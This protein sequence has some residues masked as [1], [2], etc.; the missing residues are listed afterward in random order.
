[1]TALLPAAALAQLIDQTRAP[2]AAGDGIS[3]SYAQQV[4][5][6][7]G[8]WSTPDSSSFI[9]ARDPFRAIRRGRQL[10]NR[11]F[12]REQGVGPI[13]GDGVGDINTTLAIGA[14]LSDSCAGCHGMPRGSAGFGGGVVT[15]PDGRN[16]PHLFGLGLREMLA[17][18][19]TA[20]L[21]ARR[22]EA[23]AAARR[24]QSRIT[25]P[26]TAK[27]IDYG[28]ITAGPDDAVDLSKLKGVDHDL[29]V[30][31]FFAHGGAYS[32][33]EFVVGALQNEMGMQAVDPDLAQAAAG[34]R[35]V[36]VA[37]MTLDGAL[38]KLD[39]P[40]AANA[41]ADP[42]GDGVANEA[43]QAAVDYLEFYLLNYFKPGH[44]EQNEG[45]AHGREVFTRIGCPACHIPDLQID[46]DR[47]VADVETVHDPVNGIFNRLFATATPL[48]ETVDDT[49]GFPAVKQPALKPFLVRDIFTDFK[50]H[51][52]GP[53]FYERGYD[54][55]LLKEFMTP[56]LWGIGSTPPYGHDGRSM[57]LN[58]VILRHGGE[59]QAARDAYGAL[60]RLDRQ[61]LLEFLNSLILFPPDDTASNLNP[62]SRNATDFP[63][64][65]HGSVGLTVLFNNPL[66]PE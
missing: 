26:V 39:P 3:K 1:M 33:R 13:V 36:T 20:E 18:E 23:V 28:E 29:R 57:T 7:R 11:K 31:P 56:A 43:P 65:G 45:T 37:G 21:R 49:S 14:G 66:D 30:R 55:S 38:D 32:I 42:D 64:H 17:D 50:R 19:I 41:E 63:Q 54:G 51:N 34:R 4:G 58:A 44:A 48:L 9:V 59:G 5:A 22:D 10:F 6:G 15:R 61:D 24:S 8:N 47:R 2:N 12:T 62:G 53:N 16:A 35:V 52:L 60:G 40:P 27:G 46:R 25:A